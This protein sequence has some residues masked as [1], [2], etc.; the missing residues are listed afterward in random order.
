MRL[1]A[2][3]IL[4]ITFILPVRAQQVDGKTLFFRNW[5]SAETASDGLGP[6]YNEASCHACHW[7]GGG[8]RISLRNN[9]EVAA[10]GMLLRHTFPDG[11]ADPYYGFQL[12]NKAIGGLSPEGVAD[13]SVL[14]ANDGLSRF[15]ASV[16]FSDGPGRTPGITMSLRAAP[17]LDV[18]GL[19]AQVSDKAILQH[20]DPEDSDG[21][22]ISG[23]VHQLLGANGEMRIGRFNW[24]ATM[25]EVKD[26][27]A[28]A[29]WFDMGLTSA[30]RT[31]PQ[32]E[33]TNR[34]I[35][36]LEASG[37][38]SSDL[39]LDVVD[40]E[41]AAIENHVVGFAKA[42]VALPR[43]PDAFEKAKCASCHVP[44]METR[45]GEEVA[46]FS[47]LLLH[48]MGEQLSSYGSEGS[49]M[50][51]EWRTTGL[52]G[53]RGQIPGHRFLHDGRAANVDEA[54]RWH[55]GEAEASREAYIAMTARERID[56]ASY[57]LA[58]LSSMPVPPQGD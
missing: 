19:I 55:G 34:Q 14:Q 25:A 35:A 17:A 13:V 30:G 23:R 40:D 42:P 21:D 31:R 6:L 57:V 20:A 12:Q 3:I 29:L 33:C 37:S 44:R 1:I 11:S 54:I 49:A 8:A 53:N 16:R 43:M 58:L 50:A 18:T 52:V 26:Q 10:A 45:N 32:G 27:I 5:T 39:P 15:L 51:S 2:L 24:K 48:D 7:F 56:L 41:I 28:T 22:G 47:D 9:G 46:L 36:C 4:A 38:Q